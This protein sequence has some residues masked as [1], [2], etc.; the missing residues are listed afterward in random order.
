MSNPNAAS[1]RMDNT[2]PMV[3]PRVTTIDHVRPIARGGT[4]ELEN[5][6]TS[7]C[8]CNAQKREYTL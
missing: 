8:T 2:H 1:W 6:A 3:N 5:V 7:C 4:S